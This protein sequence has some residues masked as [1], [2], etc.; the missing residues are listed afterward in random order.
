MKH[1]DVLVACPP[2]AYPTVEKALGS[3]VNL[4]PVSTLDAARHALATMPSISAIV[5]GVYFDESRMYELLRYCKQSHPVVPF[6]G[7]RV[8]DFEMP[9]V[10]LDALAIAAESL[11]A[12]RFVDVASI[13][14]RSGPAA[15]EQALRDAVLSQLRIQQSAKKG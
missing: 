1:L 2:F 14:A 13:T 8:L 4:V 9:S 6:I 7:M 12:K 5:C 15:A 10:A 3:Y 11:G